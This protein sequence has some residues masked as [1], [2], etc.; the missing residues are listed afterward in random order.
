MTTTV[1]ID[2][3]VGG[4][5][6]AALEPHVLALY[7]RPGARVVFIGEMAHIE[8]TQPAPDTDGQPS[9]KMRIS[10]LEI[11]AKE[12]EGAVRQALQALYLQR[13]AA[14]TLDEHGQVILTESTLK[15]TGGLLTE[16]ETARLRAGLAHWARYARNS[17]TTPNLVLSEVL[18]ELRTV[19]DG[20]YAVLDRAAVAGDDD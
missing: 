10:S 12:Q 17:A 20:L 13:T 14:G 2:S 15:M 16:I 11:A 5:P 3:K 4:G 6:A 1:K 19:A 9:V 18:H 7:S 8:R